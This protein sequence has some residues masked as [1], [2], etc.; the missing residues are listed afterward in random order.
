VNQKIAACC[1]RRFVRDFFGLHHGRL[2]AISHSLIQETLGNFGVRRSRHAFSL[3][4]LLP[5]KFGF[6][7]HRTRQ[8]HHLMALPPRKLI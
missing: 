6:L 8:S 2:T 4:C 7:H 3:R 5:E 1:Q